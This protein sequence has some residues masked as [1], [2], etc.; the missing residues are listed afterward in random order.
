MIWLQNHCEGYQVRAAGVARRQIIESSWVNE[1]S[2]RVAVCSR[3]FGQ[4]GHSGSGRTRLLTLSL[5]GC[6][7]SLRW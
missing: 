4:V 1:S 2:L 6:N 5:N 3:V 7:E